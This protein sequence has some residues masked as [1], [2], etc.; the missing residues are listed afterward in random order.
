MRESLL[1]GRTAMVTLI[2]DPMLPRELMS[3]SSRTGLIEAVHRYKREGH[4]LWTQWLF[5]ATEHP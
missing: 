4:Q 5:A 1:L 2:R 3:S